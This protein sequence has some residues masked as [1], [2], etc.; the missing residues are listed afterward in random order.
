MC[1]SDEGM[2]HHSSIAVALGVGC[3][4]F[5]ALECSVLSQGREVDMSDAEG[6]YRVFMV[7]LCWLAAL[8]ASDILSR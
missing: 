4:R 2:H 7:V 8:R 5:V 1:F 3:L 6:G